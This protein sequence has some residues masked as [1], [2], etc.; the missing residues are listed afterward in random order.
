MMTEAV[1]PLRRRETEHAIA[2][3]SRASMSRTS[4]WIRALLVLTVS[5]PALADTYAVVN[6]ADA[7]AGSLR[8][9]ITAANAKQVTNGSQCAPHTI[10]FNIPGAGPHTIRPLS[11]LPRI[12]IPI[13]F[14]GYSQ[15]GAS[16]NTLAQGSDAVIAIELDGSL[17]GNADAF[18]IG[19][20]IPGSSLCPGTG[21]IIRGLV[22]NRFTGAAISMGEEACPPNATCTVGGVL[23]QGNYIGTDVTGALARGNGSGRPALV[24]GTSSSFNVVG[25]Q[26][27]AEGGPSDPLPQSR[28]VISGNGADAILIASTSSDAAN[29]LSQAHTIRNNIIGLD[30]NG[31]AALPNGGRGIEVGVNGSGIAIHDNLISANAGDGVAI[32]DSPFPGTAVIGNGIGIGFDAQAFGNGGHGV[33]VAG[34]STGVTVG[35]RFRFAP[36]TASIANNAGAGLFIDG[37]ATVDAGNLSSAHNGGLALDIAPAGV[38]PNDA[39]DADIGPN[40]LLNRPVISSATTNPTTLS[41]SIAGSIS[42]APGS[43]YEIHFFINDACDAGGFGGGQVLYALN[44]PPGFVNVTTDASGNAGFTRAVQFLPQG[45]WLTALARRF[46][47]TSALPALIVSEF[48]NCMQI[49]ASGDVIFANGFE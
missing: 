28:N 16:Q 47:T 49:A 27:L 38:N 6:T 18:V 42:A 22:I 23:I 45:K 25:D 12:N 15:P 14:N 26:V 11:P 7:G 31:S 48:S 46:S 41:G 44:P 9:A 33:L 29:G 20:A 8:Q 10:T 21:S 24:F 4:R 32:L 34:G 19:A 35:A 30:A 40:E 43:N 13:T 5:A 36:T 3:M 17:A 1:A 37:M 39:G 2:R